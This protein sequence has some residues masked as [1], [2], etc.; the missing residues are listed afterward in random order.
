MTFL[1]SFAVVVG[2]DV[3]LT[4]L[5]VRLSNHLPTPSSA[6]GKLAAAM[7]AFI[8]FSAGMIVLGGLIGLLLMWASV[9]VAALVGAWDDHRSGL[10]GLLAPVS[11]FFLILASSTIAAQLAWALTARL[12]GRRARRAARA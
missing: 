8:G 3:A 11:V 4:A 6:G 1:A 12:T 7:A 2:F 9:D 10:T 5:V